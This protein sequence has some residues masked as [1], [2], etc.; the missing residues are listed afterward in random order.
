MVLHTILLLVRQRISVHV[1]SRKIHEPYLLI[2]LLNGGQLLIFHLFSE[3]VSLVF[4]GHVES[5]FIADHGVV[6]LF[7]F[8]F[9]I[10]CAAF[11]FDLICFNKVL[12]IFSRIC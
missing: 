11:F 1:T 2:G 9:D 10:F 7:L 12:K 4:L 3:K 5:F 8:I 6:G